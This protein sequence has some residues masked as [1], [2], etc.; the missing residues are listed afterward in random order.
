MLRKLEYDYR[1]IYLIDKSEDLTAAKVAEISAHNQGVKFVLFARQAGH[2]MA[3]RAGFDFARSDAIVV[4]IDGDGQHP[5]EMI[6]LLI[7]SIQNGFDVAQ[8]KR[9]RSVDHRF[10]VRIVSKIY[11]RVFSKLTGVEIESGITD[12]RAVSPRVVREVSSSFSDRTPFLR[13][14][15]SSL[16]LKSIFI[17]YDA[18]EREFG[19][20]NFSF[21]RLIKFSVEAIFSF[22]DIPLKLITRL[23]AIVSTFSILGGVLVLVFSFTQSYKLPGY[24]SI[25]FSIAFLSGLQIFSIGILGNYIRLILSEVRVRP[26]YVIEKSNL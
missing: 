12:F 2:Q 9:N 22:S 25:F 23:G 5:I 7:D 17:S 20:T 8:T 15:I 19:I 6:P 26:K 14:F 3:L 16:K 10:I 11:Y 1:I 4:S 21:A 18:K 24:T 13:G